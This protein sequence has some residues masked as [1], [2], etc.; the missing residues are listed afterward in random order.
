MVVDYETKDFKVK[1]GVNDFKF[2]M[3][4]NKR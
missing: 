1:G 4:E 3:E 2:K